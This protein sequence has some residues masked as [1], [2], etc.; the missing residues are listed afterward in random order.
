MSEAEHAVF[1]LPTQEDVAS[2]NAGKRPGN[3]LWREFD[4]AAELKAY[5]DGI[6]AIEDEFDTP[7]E[8][9][10]KGRSVVLVRDG[11]VMTVQLDD[12]ASAVA[13][14]QGAEDSEGFR[15]PRVVGRDDD[16]FAKL[17]DLGFDRVE[18]ASPAP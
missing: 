6:D 14:R 18:P 1:V 11:A 17:S 13:F 15:S 16:W 8:I 7:D 4:T 10:V 2:M 5:A 9:S 3:V 12:A